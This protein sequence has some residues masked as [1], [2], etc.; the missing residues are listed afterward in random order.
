MTK[1]EN[2][3][4]TTTTRELF[5]CYKEQAPMSETMIEISEELT[6]RA[7]ELG[8]VDTEET[9][10]SDVFAYL[11]LDE[12]RTKATDYKDFTLQMCKDHGVIYS[13]AVLNHVF[14]TTNNEY[15]ASNEMTDADRTVIE[16][17]VTAYFDQLHE[18]ATEIRRIASLFVTRQK[19]VVEQ[20]QKSQ[21]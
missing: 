3:L 7:V 11:D 18:T 16:L 1:T 14:K 10:I 9:T 5:R 12:D 19:I 8:F 21:N 2:N 4:K 20:F 15:G 6:R 17:A 13:D